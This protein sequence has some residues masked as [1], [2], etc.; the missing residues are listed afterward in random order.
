MK[1]QHLAT[2]AI[3]AAAPSPALAQGIFGYNWDATLSAQ[4]Q[5]TYEGSDEYGVGPGGS[6]ALVRPDAPNPYNAPDDGLSLT[7]MEGGRAA[8][9]LSGRFRAGRDDDDD[10]RGMEEIDWAGEV[11]VFVNL[12]LTDWLRTRLEVR[13]GFSGHEGVI[14]DVGADLVAREGRW[15]LSAGP[16]F[17][18]ADDEFTQTYFGVTAREALASPLIAAAYR[19][20]GGPRYAGAIAQADYQWTDRWGLTF[21]VGYRR[22]LGDAADSPLV[23]NLGAQDQFSAS[24]GVRYSLGR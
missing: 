5:P 3:L 20:D 2:A 14:A 4:I 22:L 12:W 18:Y 13:Q 19:P 1:L 8:I 15:I 11:G 7:L 6:I 9:G 21:D 16:R 17:S 23:R 24:A 10:L